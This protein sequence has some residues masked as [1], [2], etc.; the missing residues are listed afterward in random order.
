MLVKVYPY[1][2]YDINKDKFVLGE[3]YA[4]E[5]CIRQFGNQIIATECYY[6]NVDDLDGDGRIL[7]TTL[8]ELLNQ[9]S[10]RANKADSN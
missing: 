7:K 1:K 9:N 5:D 10:N 6:V 2:T 8:H 4:T 3:H